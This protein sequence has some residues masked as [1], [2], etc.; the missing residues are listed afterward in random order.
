LL[1]VHQFTTVSAPSPWILDYRDRSL[2]EQ[3]ASGAA[4]A[5][6]EINTIPSAVVNQWEQS[7]RQASHC[8]IGHI[9]LFAYKVQS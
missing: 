7:R 8:E 4:G 3:L 1:K 2:I 5:V 9:D 6:R